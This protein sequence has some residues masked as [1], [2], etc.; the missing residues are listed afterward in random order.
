M[1]KRY[2]WGATGPNSFDCSGF[3][4][5][6]LNAVG[7]STPDLLRDEQKYRLEKN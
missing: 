4:K 3:I 2:R 5:Y 7:V 6:V 1:G